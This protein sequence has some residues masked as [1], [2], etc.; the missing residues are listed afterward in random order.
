[1][2][3]SDM[4][5]VEASGG[6]GRKSQKAL[7]EFGNFK[8]GGRAFAKTA[9]SEAVM[10]ISG[11]DDNRPEIVSKLASTFTFWFY[12]GTMQSLKTAAYVKTMQPAV[13]ITIDPKAKSISTVVL[14]I[15]LLCLLCRERAASPS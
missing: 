4:V 3:H 1:M 12:K 10:W 15:F 6:R 2:I 13:W 9:G 11:A 14:I 8:Q 5:Q 7:R